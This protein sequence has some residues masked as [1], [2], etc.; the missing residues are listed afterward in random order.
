MARRD[1]VTVAAPLRRSHH[2]VTTGRADKITDICE[3]RLE[4]GG[5][6]I[7]THLL[8]LLL[9]EGVMP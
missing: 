2:P 1:G 6:L 4:S 5:I 3:L 7:D 9:R 8:M